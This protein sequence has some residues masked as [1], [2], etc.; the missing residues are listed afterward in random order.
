MDAD[1]ENPKKQGFCERN[2]CI[3][4]LF[5]TIIGCVVAVVCVTFLV[6]EVRTMAPAPPEAPLAWWQTT[7]IYQVY[8]RSF[9]DSNSDGIGDLRG[10]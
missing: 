1:T 7:I 9:Q 10:M 2:R 8:P 3:F 6:P 4:L 5:M